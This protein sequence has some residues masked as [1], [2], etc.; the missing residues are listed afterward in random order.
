MRFGPFSS[1]WLPLYRGQQK[2][3]KE[4]M[5]FC[6]PSFA[7]ASVCPLPQA[8]AVAAATRQWHSHVPAV[9]LPRSPLIRCPAVIR[10]EKYKWQRGCASADR[11]SHIHALAAPPLRS[12][13][14][15]PLATRITT[16]RTS[17]ITV[18]KGRID[19]GGGDRRR[20]SE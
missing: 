10:Y 19:P 15:F 12:P 16:A 5:R 7:A 6:R 20:N 14:Q 4:G 1:E 9:P 11:L 18:E 17:R 8:A 2:Q 13:L 3:T